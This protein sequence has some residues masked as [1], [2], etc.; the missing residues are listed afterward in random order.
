MRKKKP[1]G[2]KLSKRS[3]SVVPF[4]EKKSGYKYCPTYLRSGIVVLLSNLCKAIIQQ[5]KGVFA[6]LFLEEKY[7]GNVRN[8]TRQWQWI[9]KRIKRLSKVPI[10]IDIC[11]DFHWANSMKQNLLH[12]VSLKFG[13]YESQKIVLFDVKSRL[14]S[15]SAQNTWFQK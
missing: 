2:L 3:V 14:I 6:L 10:N 9:N 11:I 5:Y 1:F 13:C 4:G 12:E 8:V 7:D 15:I